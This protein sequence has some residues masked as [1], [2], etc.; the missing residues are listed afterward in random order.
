MHRSVCA[1]YS[2]SIAYTLEKRP[3]NSWPRGV[4]E[5]I[6]VAKRD[7]AIAGHGRCEKSWGG[8]RKN[9]GKEK[10]R[11]FLP[12]LPLCNVTGVWVAYAFC[13]PKT[14]FQYLKR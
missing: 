11:K 14:M 1:K 9:V 8:R 3:R 13:L 12:Y 10:K 4:S 5:S 6:S 7:G 2:P